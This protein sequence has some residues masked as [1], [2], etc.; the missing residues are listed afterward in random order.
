M[1]GVPY[2]NQYDITA[3]LLDD[4]FTSKPDFTPYF[5]EM[6]DSRVFDAEKAMKKYNKTMDWRKIT[7]GPSMDDEDHQR[8]EH[9]KKAE[10]EK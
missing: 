6:H 7:Q 1:L 10:V 5:L 4:C 3:S 8:K 2:V 9:Y